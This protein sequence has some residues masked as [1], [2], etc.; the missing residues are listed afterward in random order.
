MANKET[1]GC[2]VE[3]ER[4]V[5]GAVKRTVPGI[6]SPSEMNQSSFVPTNL[7]S[8][9]IIIAI[10]ILCVRHRQE[11][12]HFFPTTNNV[13]DKGKVHVNINGNNTY[14]GFLFTKQPPVGCPATLQMYFVIKFF[15][16]DRANAKNSTYLRRIST[17]DL[18]K[19]HQKHGRGCKDDF[20]GYAV[21]TYSR[22]RKQEKFTQTT[23]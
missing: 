10:I 2:K 5:R 19:R 8:T 1:C 11:N 3:T 23:N 14:V 4:K 16:L 7:V 21:T 6:N 22:L 20:T 9:V 17:D 12:K 18:F 13:P 15:V